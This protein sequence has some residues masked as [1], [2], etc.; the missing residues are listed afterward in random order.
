MLL[1]YGYAY[2]SQKKPLP[3]HQMKIKILP[4]SLFLAYGAAVAADEQPP[5]RSSPRL[6]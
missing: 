5:T 4:L 2:A 1:R 6:K 3:Y